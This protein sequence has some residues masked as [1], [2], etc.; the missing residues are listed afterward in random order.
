MKVVLQ[1]RFTPILTVYDSDA[2]PSTISKKI[3]L[4]VLKPVVAVTDG[5]DN[6]YYKTGDF[7]PSAFRYVAISALIALGWFVIKRI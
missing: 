2:P 4:Q 3:A 7:Y 5:N 6:V 1:T